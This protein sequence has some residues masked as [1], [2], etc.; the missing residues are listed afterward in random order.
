MLYASHGLVDANIPTWSALHERLRLMAG[1]PAVTSG[2][3]VLIF[4]AG[5]NRYLGRRDIVLDDGEPMLVNP[6][7]GC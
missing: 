6:A 7:V 4:D 3:H 5:T 2:V 1:Q